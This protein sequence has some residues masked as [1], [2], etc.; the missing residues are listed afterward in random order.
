MEVKEGALM[1]KRYQATL[2]LLSDSQC[3]NI[4]LGMILNEVFTICYMIDNQ[5]YEDNGELGCSVATTMISNNTLIKP[6]CP[7]SYT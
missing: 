6:C 1:T 5:Y 4:G 7:L 2:I 3:A